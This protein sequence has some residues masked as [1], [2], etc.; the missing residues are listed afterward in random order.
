M[1]LILQ[2][3]QKGHLGQKEIA[4]PTFFV[5]EKA[6]NK[7]LHVAQIVRNL[8]LAEIISNEEIIPKQQAIQE[9][10]DEGRQRRTSFYIFD[11]DL[12]D[13]IENCG[14]TEETYTSIF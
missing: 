12:E 3:K 11:D 13:C 14:V 1:P 10:K 7:E 9:M 8:N 4:K 5:A 2:H 6:Q